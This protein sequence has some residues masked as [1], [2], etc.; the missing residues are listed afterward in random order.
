MNQQKCHVIRVLVIESKCY[1]PH[2]GTSDGLIYIFHTPNEKFDLKHILKP[3]PTYGPVRILRFDHAGLNLA[4]GHD[5]GVCE[6]SFQSIF[7]LKI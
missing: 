5:T 2:L 4:T 6:V 1:F 3:N 7:S